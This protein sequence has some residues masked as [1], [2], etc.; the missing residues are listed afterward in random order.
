MIGASEPP[1]V[2]VAIGHNERLAWGLTIAGNDQEDVYVEEVNPANGNEV[3]FRGAWEP[4]RILREPIVVK[5]Q[6]PEIVELRFTRHGPIFYEDTARHSARTSS[7]RRC[8]NRNAPYLGGPQTFAGEDC[9]QFLDAAMYW[10]APTENLICGDIDGN[11]S[12]QA[13]ALTPNRTAPK[14]DASRRSWM[15]RLPVPGTGAYEWEGFRRICR[16]I[17]SAAR[18]HRHRQQ[19]D[20]A[21]G[22]RAADDVQD[23]DNVPFDRITRLLQMIKPD[24]ST[25]STITA[26]CSFDA[27]SCARSPKC[28][29]SSGWTSAN[30][31]VEARAGHD[32]AVGRRR[33]R[34]TARPP[35]STPRGAPRRHPGTRC[36]APGGGTQGLSTRPK[37]R[38][39]H[40]ADKE[41][42]GADWSAWRWGRMHTRPFPHPLVPG[43]TCRR[44]SGLA[45]P[46]LSRRMAPATVK[47]LTSPTGIDRS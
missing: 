21:E 17:Q 12:W 28:R 27:M 33:S 42:Q 29:C 36:G 37:P 45:A 10:K 24:G 31:E 40:R 35:R 23:V 11:I 30:A 18:L 4:V 44:S 9:R 3:K 47:S 6:A 8:S 25:R 5:G 7:G 32:R 14:N 1:F 13:S 39:R 22:L 34:G 38:A 43:S 26:A 41:S 46:A 19:P 15:G 2:G 20:P 16:R